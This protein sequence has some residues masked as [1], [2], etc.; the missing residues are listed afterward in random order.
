MKILYPFI[1]VPSVFFPVGRLEDGGTCEFASQKCLAEC[2]VYKHLFCN[3]IIHFQIKEAIF[4][5]F[6][7]QDPLSLV[8]EVLSE[9]RE[10]NSNVLCWFAS[11]DC[12]TKHTERICQIARLLQM[13][14]INQSIITRSHALYNLVRQK[15]LESYA[16]IG[17]ALTTESIKE[18]KGV[19]LFVV[20]DYKKGLIQFFTRTAKD[21]LVFSSSFSAYDS[22]H[23]K[24]PP[25]NC[26]NCLAK[27]V[28][29]FG[30]F[31]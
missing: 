7:T 30:E 26:K 1:D 5:R 17:I 23:K 19:G 22:Q 14:G 28:G 25:T 18:I 8:S 20:P 12:P 9:M 2:A 27:R 31:Y 16:R 3:H 21:G 29:C 15:R 10:A 24:T 11:G 6:T 13:K 4:E